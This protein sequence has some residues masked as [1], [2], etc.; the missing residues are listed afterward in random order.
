MTMYV[1]APWSSIAV[2]WSRTGNG[3]FAT[4]DG[5][6]RAIDCANTIALNLEGID[7]R[8]RAGIH[9]GESNCVTATLAAWP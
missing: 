9:T 5:P 3:I 6:G 8:I 2:T 4:F 1:D 7:L